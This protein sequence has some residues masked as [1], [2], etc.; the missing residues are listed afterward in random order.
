MTV[1]TEYQISADDKTKAGIDSARKN[2]AAFEKGAKGAA[3]SVSDAFSKL[4]GPLLGAV[5]AAQGL[6]K[7]VSVTR[8]FDVLNAG[9]ITATG[10][11]ENA[12]IAFGAIQQF[13]AT[14][15]Y[16]IQ[17][18]TDSFIKLTN[19]GLQPSERAINA[20]GDTASAM[21][22][23]LDQMVEAVA[24]AATGEFER[25]KEFGIKASK[26]GDEVQFTFRGVT[27]TVKNS[28]AEIQDYLISLGENNF[29]G[30]MAQR[31]DSLDGA[32]SNLGDSWDQLFLNI[33]KQGAGDLITDSVRIAIRA[34]DELNA[35]LASGQLQGYF[36]AYAS[37]F[38]GFS[39][40]IQNAI[41]MFEG[42]LL[43][44]ESATEETIDFIVSAFRDL[45]QNVR[46]FLQ[47]LV[48]EMV[49]TFDKLVL[50]AEAVKDRFKAVFTDDTID[51]VNERLFKS[52]D[53]VNAVRQDS[54][55]AILS[56]RD[57][58]I[59]SYNDQIVKADEARAKFEEVAA[60][61]NGGDRLAQFEVGGASAN[62]DG[63]GGTGSGGGSGESEEE[64]FIRRIEQLR[65]QNLTELEVEQEKYDNS[66]A[67]LDQALSAEVLKQEE[68]NL[69]RESIEA[70]HEANLT[71]ISAKGLSDREKFLAKSG[72]DQTKQ[73]F[74]DLANITAGVA[75]H[76]KGLFEL[77]KAAGIANAI[78]NTYEG[79]SKSLSAYPMP[80]AAVMAAAHL[81]S[82]MAQVAAIKSTQ[83]GSGSAGATS[84]GGAP[85]TTAP[86]NIAQNA[87]V[88]TTQEAVQEKPQ[89]V[90]INIEQD[91][92]YSGRQLRQLM[93][94]LSEQAGFNVKFGT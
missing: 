69:M 51:A 54:I 59:A 46:A 75:N 49:S 70:K 52:L 20:Y 23:S 9:L 26:Q 13:A 94:Q 32:L 14:T 84:V 89:T 16:D 93:E 30:A 79:V 48:V 65:T 90:Y 29:A 40:D 17:Q 53:G 83:F 45:P 77:N 50:N 15:P 66:L 33:S 6:S 5:S 80:L 91:A 2:F 71:K 56:E 60:A 7:L 55:S 82:G 74:G 24:D 37:G 86:S 85:V 47:I 19:Y 1:K 8:E 62:D 12:A 88:S 73:V 35:M 42:E 43:A 22:K 92:N 81:A 39:N 87:Q 3:D 31:M 67:L 11:A 38:S 41:S 57:A 63:T 4:A 25:L 10:S 76:N 44:G 21:G 27:S 64:K 28:S 61:K 68:Y 36:K 34:I 78:I 72:K 18:V 58:A